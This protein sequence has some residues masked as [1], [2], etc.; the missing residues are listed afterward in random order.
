MADEKKVVMSEELAMQE[1]ERW[2][3]EN[4]FDLYVKG[5]NGMQILDSSVP[6]LMKAIQNGSLV[7]NDNNEFEYTVSDKS[8]SGFAGEKITFKTPSGAGFMAMD[9]Y[10]DQESVHKQLAVASAATGKD[11]GWFGKLSARDYKIAFII[12]GFFIA[13]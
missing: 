1:I 8:P 9:S 2:A 4:D 11:V 3:D 13:G 5:P 10:K 6:K 7:L 12:A